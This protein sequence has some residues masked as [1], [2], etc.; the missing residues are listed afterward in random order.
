MSIFPGAPPG[1]AQGFQMAACN[2]AQQML[3][4][5]GESWG[6]LDI[7]R[8]AWNPVTLMLD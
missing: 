7:D 2:E 3:E 4:V 8:F 6:M 1:L 5:H